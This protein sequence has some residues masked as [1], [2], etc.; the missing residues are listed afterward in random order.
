M[1]GI[2]GNRKPQEAAVRRALEDLPHQ[3][4]ASVLIEG[5]AVTAVLSVEQGHAD[6][7]LR[8]D[9]EKRLYAL[10][11]V[12]RASVI[13]TA[14]RAPS[15]KHGKPMKRPSG[16][17]EL[18]VKHIIAVAS[19]KGGVGKSTVA[20]NL[21]AG[22]TILGFK[23]GLLDADIY[24]PS[25]PR[26]TGMRDQKPER[27]NEKIIPIEA[28]GMKLMS[29]GFLVDEEAPMIWRGPMIQSAI[30]Q[31]LSDVDWRGNDVL[32]IDLPPGTGDAQLTLAQQV[33]MTGAVI[34]STPQDI[35]LV[36]A[37][38]G[39]EMFRKTNVPILGVVENMSYFCC[40]SCGTRSE[41]F[42]HGGARDSAAAANVAFLG[43]IPLDP[44]IRQ[45]SDEGKPVVLTEPHAQ[46]A[47][48]FMAIAK[49]IAAG[50]S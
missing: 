27:V 24:G 39:L 10:K 13:L 48:A 20:I 2:L 21:A 50:L 22:L 5:R 49:T 6:E 18:P 11:G 17:I 29:M 46:Q 26:L 32:V 44:Q 35:A 19:G 37:R 4:I 47:K 30:K 31:L 14:E 42:G 34:V 8:L 40:P 16:P 28:H 33:A 41:I 1:L 36:D 9:A 25:L 38:K 3:G 43:E 23:V 45:L 7:S 12:D 15:T